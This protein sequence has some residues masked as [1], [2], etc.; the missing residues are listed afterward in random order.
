MTLQFLID[1]FLIPNKY[2]DNE[3]IVRILYS[4]YHIDEEKGE[5]KSSAFHPPINKDD[6]SKSNLDISILRLNYT[7]LNFCKKHGKRFSNPAKTYQGF[8]IFTVSDLN[9]C[10]KPDESEPKLVVTKLFQ[11]K[12]RIFLPMH[13]DIIMGHIENGKPPNNKLKRR[14]KRIKKIVR[15]L[16]DPAPDSRKW[17]GEKVSS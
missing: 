3:V 2:D 11:L 7:N 12:K 10:R 16:K 6:P 1:Y 13:G 17:E 5:I 15:L 4:P 8:G 14:A 9:A